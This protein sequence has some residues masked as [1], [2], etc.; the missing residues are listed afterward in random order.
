MYYRSLRRALHNRTTAK[1]ALTAMI[2]ILFRQIRRRYHAIPADSVQSVFG[3]V[4]E[5]PPSQHALYVGVNFVQEHNAKLRQQ[6][7]GFRGYKPLAPQQ[8]GRKPKRSR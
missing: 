5:M 7:P 8:V 6:G 1:F 2:S 4:Q 3:I